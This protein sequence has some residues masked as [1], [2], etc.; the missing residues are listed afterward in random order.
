MNEGVIIMP[1]EEK[2]ESITIVPGECLSSVD[3]ARNDIRDGD[4][5]ELRVIKNSPRRL[6]IKKIGGE[7]KPTEGFR[8]AIIN[9][10]LL[11]ET[12]A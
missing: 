10:G 9:A 4:F 6:D 7:I 11:G 5:A 1:T 2:I 12:F 8:T 3:R